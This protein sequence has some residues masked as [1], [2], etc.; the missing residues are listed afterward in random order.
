MSS[1]DCFV[2]FS[3][4]TSPSQKNDDAPKIDWLN[5]PCK[6]FF[7][8]LQKKAAGTGKITDFFFADAQRT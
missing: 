1:S 7:P 8:W 4:L 3:S 2:S 6:T 5:V